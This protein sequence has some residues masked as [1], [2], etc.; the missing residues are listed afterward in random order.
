[1]PL[2]LKMIVVAAL[3]VLNFFCQIH[4]NMPR[5]ISEMN[6]ENRMDR[7]IK[8]LSGSSGTLPLTGKIV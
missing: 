6:I 5:Q 2:H 8:P 4:L 7:D 1:M 3:L